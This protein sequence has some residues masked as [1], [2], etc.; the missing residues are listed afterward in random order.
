MEYKYTNMRDS[1]LRLK[2]MKESSLS[3][4]VAVDPTPITAGQEVTILYNGLL[5]GAGADQVYLHMGYGNN[6]HW[7]A[8]SDQSMHRTGWGW[9]KTVV[10]TEDSRFNFCFKDSAG[11]WDNNSGKNWSY[12]VHNGSTY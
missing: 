5:S 2:E 3:G 8:I 9:E 4:G 12:E 10:M 11:N 6:R 7:S 1:E